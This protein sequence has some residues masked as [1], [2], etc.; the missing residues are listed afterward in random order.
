[1][2]FRRSVIRALDRPGGRALLGQAITYFA[3]RSVPDVRVFFER[4]MWVH[5]SRGATF[6]DS[7]NC[8][9]YPA[10]FPTWIGEFERCRAVAEDAWFHANKPQEGDLIVD[11]GAGK[12]ED[13]VAFSKYV[14]LGG[15]VIAIEAH[16]VTYR[17]LRVFCELNHLQNVTP[18]NYAITDRAGPVTIES[19]EAWQTNSVV[20][21]GR[22]GT[23]VPG[24]TLDEIVASERIERID[25]LKMNIEGAE[26]SAIK[27]MSKTLQITRA[28]CISCHDFR[29]ARGHGDGFRTKELI[30]EWVQAAGFKIIS[31]DTDPR[32]SVADQ[33]NAI[34]VA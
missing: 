18:L 17:C 9:Y 34:R 19:T 15:R 16:P 13:T 23:A 20:H 30:Q 33:V 26:A 7:P 29:A 4:G 31:R 14:G 11:V 6:V 8:D 24:I 25:L 12:G 5:A 3:R 2:A 28:L 27:G 22:N 32:P 21:G 10:M 1:M